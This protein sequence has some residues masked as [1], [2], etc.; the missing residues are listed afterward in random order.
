MYDVTRRALNCLTFLY[1]KP[2]ESPVPDILSNFQTQ[3]VAS[4][5]LQTQ[6]SDTRDQQNT[7]AE[8]TEIEAIFQAYLKGAS[9]GPS[10]DTLNEATKSL[11]FLIVRFLESWDGYLRE[12]FYAGGQLQDNE[13]ELLAYEAS[14]AFSSLSFNVPLITAQLD[15]AS[16]E[17]SVAG[18]LLSKLSSSWQNV[19]TSSYINT[20]QRQIS[21]LG[22]AL[23]DAY[24]ILKKVPRP[25]AGERPDPD[26]PS[27]IIHA[28]TYSLNYWQRA[29][30]W[31]CNQNNSAITE[32]ATATTAIIEKATTNMTVST[33]P[34]STTV[35]RTTTEAAIETATTST[36]VRTSPSDETENPLPLTTELSRQLCQALQTQTGIWQSLMLGQQTLRSFTT[37]SVTRRILNNIMSDFEGVA[38]QAVSKPIQSDVERLRT[39]MI[40]VGILV[41]VIIGGGIILLT[42]TGQLQS[43]AAVIALFVGSALTLVSAGLTRVSSTFFP[44]SNQQPPSSNTSANNANLEQRL[45]SLFGQAGEA[46]VTAFQDAYN[47]QC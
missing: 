11:S 14:Y 13:L 27:N 30:Q 2:E 40:V 42:L 33:P 24:Y 44:A 18:Q 15:N 8:D 3:I 36:T 17:D 35:N 20:M 43:L 21:A 4:F 32:S 12:N 22:P 6:V 10:Q 38:S 5:H 7:H 46:I 34:V 47:K 26:L 25:V 39:P 9:A 37:E 23:D 19:F 29:V 45:S 28:I 31:I 1:T 41:F 16:E